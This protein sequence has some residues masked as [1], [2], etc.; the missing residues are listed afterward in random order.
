MS[1][2]IA[3]G[4]KTILHKSP[5]DIIILTALRTPITRAHKGGLKDTFPEELLG[6]ILSATKTRLERSGLDLTTITK[7]KPL[8]QDIIMGTV[9]MELG[10]AKSGR[11]AALDAGSVAW[12]GFGLGMAD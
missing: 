4:L 10:G 7:G 11:L 9:L 3:K 12:C 2:F 1:A 6:H 8:I 5:N